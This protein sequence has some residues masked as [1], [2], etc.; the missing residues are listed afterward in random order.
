MKSRAYHCVE[1]RAGG[2]LRL[3]LRARL[4]LLAACALLLVACQKQLPELPKLG[5]VAPFA[6]TDQNAQEFSSSALRG[7]PWVGAFFFTRCPTICPKITAR[8]KVLADF[9]ASEKLP[10]KLVSITIDPEH[11]TPEV[12]AAYAKTHALDLSRMTLLRGDM[13]RVRSLSEATFKL[14]LSASPD[15]EKDPLGMIHSGHLV[16]VDADGQLRGHYPTSEDAA[17]RRLEV[18]LLRLAGR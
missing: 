7:T 4:A 2:R 12:L 13:E 3:A 16:L 11:D 8:M 15:P 9:G 6:F 10:F 1:R 14:A 18:D 17:M 5:Q